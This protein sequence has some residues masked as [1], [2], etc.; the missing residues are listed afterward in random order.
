M[1]E[2]A[3]LE[4]EGEGQD[5]AAWADAR[6]LLLRRPELVSNDAD[7][8]GALGLKPVSANVVEFLPAALARVEAERE[9]ETDARR[10][11][12]RVA[13]ANFAAQA[14]TGAA[15]LDLLEARNN[16]DL[17][18]R[19]DEAARGRFDL[20]AAALATE[21]PEPVP[22]GWRDLPPGGVDDLLGPGREARLGSPCA[23]EMLFGDLAAQVGSTA[24]IRMRLWNEDRPGLLAFASPDPEGFTP[25]M[26][27]ELIAHLARV[28]ERV[29]GRWPVL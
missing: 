5:V 7:L 12:E 3:E 17:A 24:L 19:A 27:A 25:A 18:R 1:A 20:L 9:R 28:I 14:Q 23:P 21:T 10:A 26:G 13:E 15:A 16:A 8:L 29:A 4:R 6:R 22:L 11:I 2:R